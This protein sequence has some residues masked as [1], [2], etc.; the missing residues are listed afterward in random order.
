MSN[1]T[2]TPD[3]YLVTVLD[4]MAFAVIRNSDQYRIGT[5]PSVEFA[6][7]VAANLDKEARRVWVKAQRK[8]AK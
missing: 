6:R 8:A 7:R 3:V 4:E 1:N 2:A 5:Y